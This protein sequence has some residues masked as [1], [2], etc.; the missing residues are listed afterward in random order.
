MIYDA[1][2]YVFIQYFYTRKT[3]KNYMKLFCLFF[4]Y[5]FLDNKSKLK[6][7]GHIGFQ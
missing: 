4:P 6:K 1:P 3:G 2:V 5:I 7:G